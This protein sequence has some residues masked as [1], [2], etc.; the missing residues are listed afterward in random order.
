AY[1]ESALADLEFHRWIWQCSG[2]RTLCRLLDQ[3][4]APLFA[5][6]SI[7]RSRGGED[8]KRVVLSHQ[9]IVEAL[10]ARDPEAARQAVRTHIENS[11]MQYL[12]F[13]FDALAA[14]MAEPHK[15]RAHAP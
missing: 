6:I 5:F 8:L 10:A 12:K 7:R 2:D 9:P 15:E 14:V 4:T 13:D 1:F 11:C 3:L